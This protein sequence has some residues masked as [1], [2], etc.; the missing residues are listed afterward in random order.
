MYYC[1]NSPGHGPDSKKNEAFSSPVFLI[2]SNSMS[3]HP[4]LKAK[5][6]KNISWIEN[7]L[8]FPKG[9]VEL[10]CLQ[11]FHSTSRS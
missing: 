7:I 2:K 4:L 1:I 9:D 10:K 5:R 8:K 11:M 3:T 6:L